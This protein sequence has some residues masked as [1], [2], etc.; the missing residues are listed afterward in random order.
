MVDSKIE[1]AYLRV[2]L[3]FN[4][5][6]NTLIYHLYGTP[7]RTA[8]AP[9]SKSDSV[10]GFDPVEMA[11]NDAMQCLAET[12]LGPQG[13]P[14]VD[15]IKASDKQISAAR[16]ER[17]E[18][19]LEKAMWKRVSAQQL[20]YAN[21]VQ[22]LKAGE[23]YLTVRRHPAR[24]TNLHSLA[25]HLTESMSEVDVQ[26]RA[27]VSELRQKSQLMVQKNVARARELHVATT[28]LSPSQDNTVD[29]STGPNTLDAKRPDEVRRY[30][31][32]MYAHY[33]DMITSSLHMLYHCMDASRSSLLLTPSQ[34]TQMFEW[35]VTVHYLHLLHAVGE[36][37]AWA[38]RVTPLINMLSTLLY[39]K[40]F[41]MTPE[42]SSTK[43]P[44][45]VYEMMSSMA[46][47]KEAKHDF[48]HP[49]C[50]TLLT[51]ASRESW[52]LD[53]L[54]EAPGAWFQFMAFSFCKQPFLSFHEPINALYQRMED[55]V[56]RAAEAIRGL[57]KVPNEKKAAVCV[58]LSFD[59]TGSGTPKKKYRDMSELPQQAVVV[60]DMF[61][62]AK[63]KAAMWASNT[64]FQCMT[65][66][67]SAAGSFQ[68]T[69][70]QQTHCVR[71]DVLQPYITLLAML[72]E[73]TLDRACS[74]EGL[75]A[76]FIKHQKLVLTT[77]PT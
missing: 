54:E 29:Y 77:T 7:P 65:Y 15:Y 27:S 44:H 50:R 41:R 75:L 42:D 5:A 39:I 12:M 20:M 56:K 19:A 24:K 70:W 25:A 35:R 6:C 73:I 71:V 52:I 31:L 38:A 21:A 1:S 49:V 72:E 18:G 23:L 68:L 64:I 4:Q 61:A 63:A 57:K 37:R 69:A 74:S 36:Q 66:L 51:S 10:Y 22:Q 11:V 28:A 55:H 3:T 13:R 32:Y 76:L 16:V 43:L 45:I 30:M 40:L 33:S 26:K 62:E 47:L 14:L 67:E 2:Q 59:M 58:G 34:I 53:N 8:A 17:N 60:R 9:D 48:I 46:R